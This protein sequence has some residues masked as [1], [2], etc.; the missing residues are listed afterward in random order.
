M[1]EQE[2]QNRRRENEE[3]A[4]A[5]RARILG[6]PYLDTRVFEE[7]VPLTK[8]LLNIEEM[9]KNF[10]LPLHKGGNEEHFQFMVTSQTP[11]TL[12][13]KMRQSY[14]DEGEKVDFFLISGSAYKEGIIQL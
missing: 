11:R 7:N 9:H 12:I 6:L 3:T 8:G 10:I 1:D 14:A 5:E 2:I 13:Q 4:T